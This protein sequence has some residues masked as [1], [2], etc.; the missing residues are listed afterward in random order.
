[1]TSQK[2]IPT[3]INSLLVFLGILILIPIVLPLGILFMTLYAIY[4]LCKVL[5]YFLVFSVGCLIYDLNPKRLK[6]KKLSK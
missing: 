3:G 4:S 6:E 2:N 5:G 1:M